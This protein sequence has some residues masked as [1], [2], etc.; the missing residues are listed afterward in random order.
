[1]VPPKKPNLI[2]G[3]IQ[4]SAARKTLEVIILL[5]LVLARPHMQH[6]KRLPRMAVQ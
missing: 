2:S 3:C 6:W 5:H 1:M 4:R